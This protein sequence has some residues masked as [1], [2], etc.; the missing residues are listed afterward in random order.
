MK[1]PQ[2]NEPGKVALSVLILFALGTLAGCAAL[3]GTNTE[4]KTAVAPTFSPAA[5]SYGVAQT[6]TIASTTEGTTI[7]Y[8]KDGT[9]PTDAYGTLYT[10]P[11]SVDAT[12][13]IKAIAYRSGW[14]ASAVSTSSYVL[15]AASSNW[16]VGFAQFGSESDWRDTN[17]A[18]VQKSFN[19][20]P[21]FALLYSDAL[22]QQANQIAALRSFIARPVDCILFT[23]LGE[24][25]YG[26]VLQEA[27]TANIPVIMID[28]SIQESDRGLLTST[29][30]Y[31]FTTQGE[32]AGTWLAAYLTAQGIDNGSTPINIVE[33]QGTT[34][35]GPTIDRKAGFASI[36]AQHSNWQ[37]TQSQTANFNTA[38]GK[39]VMASFLAADTAIRVLYSHNDAMA[40]GAIQAVKEAGLVPGTDI[41]IV[42]V[43]AVKPALQ[44]IVDG[45]MNCTVECS[46]L[47]GPQVL[48]AITDLRNGTPLPTRIW[49]NDT[50]FDATNAAAALPTREY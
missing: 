45:D 7:R 8:T 35:M 30:G 26:D 3:F 31:N 9:T 20:D 50:V 14:T 49:T 6:V 27:K 16:V 33:L 12:M 28:R 5:G 38:D 4:T 40:L 43:D 32:K 46:P 42:G 44:A 24:S 39:T 17:S 21:S 29:I 25:G 15:S 47:V 19:I 36:M 13:T 2:K 10:A 34:G 22:N 37:L 41:V 11:L 48:Q 1:I 18:S 23:P